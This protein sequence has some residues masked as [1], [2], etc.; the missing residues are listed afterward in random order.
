VNLYALLT[1][2]LNRKGAK[3][4]FWFCF[5]ILLASIGVIALGILV[6]RGVI[7]SGRE[8]LFMAYVI[9]GILIIVSTAGLIL[10]GRYLKETSSK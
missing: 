4:Y 10:Y 8:G 7:D 5:G 9:A 3:L 1:R 2:G 6:S